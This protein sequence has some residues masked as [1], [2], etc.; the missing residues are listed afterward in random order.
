MIIDDGVG[1]GAVIAGIGGKKATDGKGR[2]D[3]G[4]L[5]LWTDGL[6]G[7][8]KKFRLWSDFDEETR[9]EAVRGIRTVVDDMPAELRAEF[10]NAVRAADKRDKG[11]V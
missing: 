10:R 1:L 2:K 7:L 11:E 3:Y 5:K 9:R 8:R 4:P 6:S